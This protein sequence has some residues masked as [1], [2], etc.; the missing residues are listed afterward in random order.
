M[1]PFCLL[2]KA[3]GA[4]YDWFQKAKGM[5]D[6]Q[7]TAGGEHLSVLPWKPCGRNIKSVTSVNILHFSENRLETYFGIHCCA[8]MSG[9]FHGLL[10]FF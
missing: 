5:N 7:E 6:D 10:G 2:V 4:L 8:L 1:M 9:V 3:I